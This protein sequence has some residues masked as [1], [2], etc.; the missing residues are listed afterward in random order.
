VN[1]YLFASFV[2]NLLKTRFATFVLMSF[3]LLV[4]VLGGFL[5]FRYDV[6]EIVEPVSPSVAHGIAFATVT[7][8]PQL[9]LNEGQRARQFLPTPA[10][11]PGANYYAG[12]NELG[13]I[14]ILEYHRIGYPEMRFQRTPENFRADLERLYYSGYYPVNFIDMIH[15]LPHVPAG[16]KPVVLTFD[17]SDISQFRILADSHIDADSALGLILNFHYE[18]EAEWPPRATFFVLGN[19]TRDYMALFGQPEWAKAKIRYLI[20][21]GM[22][23]GSHTVNHTD[24]SRVTA[25]RIEWELA[26]SQH[27]IE[28]IAPGYKVQTLAVPYGG[29]PWSLTFLKAGQ[30]GDYGYT[31]AGNVAA[32]GGPTL[33]PFDPAF[34]PYRVSRLEVSDIW[35]DHWLTYFEQNPGEYY[36]SD[37]D[38]G[39]LTFPQQEIAAGE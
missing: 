6:I 29:F 1:I 20:D 4:L 11:T 8:R 24:L 12:A 7:P 14:I 2:F 17:D 19:D 23:V 25:E 36:V 15:G 9:I 28:Q 16:K 38:P 10:P 39:R 22:E 35:I 27:V 34:E 18:H 37:G 30:W 33:S 21:L 5:L 3:F 26:I 32:W 13:K 31:Y